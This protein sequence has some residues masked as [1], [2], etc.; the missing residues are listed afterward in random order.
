MTIKIART[1]KNTTIGIKS[2][3]TVKVS[4]SDFLNVCTKSIYFYLKTY[5]P[6]ISMQA[7]VICFDSSVERK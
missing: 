1:V 6:F 5:P 4:L 3:N 2:K 7:P